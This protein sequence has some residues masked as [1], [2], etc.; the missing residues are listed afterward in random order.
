MLFHIRTPTRIL[1][2]PSL[3]APVKRA[4]RRRIAAAIR[5]DPTNHHPLH[6]TPLQKTTQLRPDESIIGILRHDAVISRN[7][8]NL[9]YQLPVPAARGYGTVRAPLAHELVPVGR[10]E[11]FFGVAVLREQEREGGGLEVSAEFEDVGQ[12]GPGHGE[13][14]VLHVD[15]EEDGGHDGWADRTSRR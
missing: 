12:S 5:H 14:D 13:E 3:I 7:L 8:P 15:N 4:P 2:K 10:R 1:H 6:R 11:G 9:R